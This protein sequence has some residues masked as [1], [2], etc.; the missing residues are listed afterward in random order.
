MHIVKLGGSLFN[1][2]RLHLWLQTL[3]QAAEQTAI[4]IVPGGGPF[5]DTVRDAQKTHTFDDDTAHHMALL[6]MKQFGLMLLALCPN[7]HRYHYPEPESQPPEAGLHIWLP[8]S[9][10]M[11]VSEIPRHWQMTSDSLALWLAQQH[12]HSRLALIKSIEAA[13]QSIDVLSQSGAI[14]ACFPSLY[15]ADPVEVT[16]FYE[17]Q[18]SLFPQH[19]QPLC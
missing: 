12:S 15:Q 17:Q 19:G 3:Q 1:S 5:A 7:A 18:P 8:D 11:A 4:I 13:S 10:M 9:N 16:W 6:A 14:D 2:P